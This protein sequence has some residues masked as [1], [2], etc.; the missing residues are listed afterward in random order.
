[1]KYLYLF[2]QFEAI[3]EFK[4]TSKRSDESTSIIASF[5]GSLA[6]SITF[7]EVINSWY[8]FEGIISQEK[9]EDMFEDV[10]HIII[11]NIKVDRH[12][13]K[14]GL[15]TKLMTKAL[16]YISKNSNAKIVVL[17]A[18]P[19]DKNPNDINKISLQDLVKFYK[20][21][22]FNVYHNQGDNVIM[23]KRITR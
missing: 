3:D 13:Q 14:S 7:E 1:M 21:F 4:F 9:Y 11:E 23:I 8:W 12:Y 19:L 22:G 2:R 18:S 5:K 20:K 6:G 17:N 16:E 15:G 10:S